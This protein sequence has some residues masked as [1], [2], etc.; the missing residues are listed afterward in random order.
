MGYGFPAAIGAKVGRTKDIV[1]DIAGDGSIQMNIQELATAVFYNIPVIVA[2]L[3][4]SRLG[5]VRQWQTM[6]YD[7]RYSSTIIT[8]P[9]FVQLAEAYGALGLRVTKAGEVQP[10]LEKALAA[11]KPVLIDFVVDPEA[12]VMPM[13]PPGGAINKMMGVD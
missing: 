10:A 2:I 12:D 1:I 5:M 11:N 9:D 8:G 13:V 7:E 6:F 3:N 4:N